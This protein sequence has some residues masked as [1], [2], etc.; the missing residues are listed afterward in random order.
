M[1]PDSPFAPSRGS[2]VRPVPLPT[3]EPGDSPTFSLS[4]NC[5][6]LPFIRG[7]LQ[8]L[9]LQ[10]TW[11]TNDPAAL[12]QVQQRVFNLIDL[13]GE[14]S[15]L[16]IPF[17]CS[18]DL[19]TNASPYGTFATGFCGHWTPLIGYDSDECN[20]GSNTYQGIGIDLTFSTPVVLSSVS[21]HYDLFMG[22]FAGCSGPEVIEHIVDVT[23]SSV[24]Q[25]KTN[26]VLTNGG[27]QTLVRSGLTA[28]TSH[29]NVELDADIHCGGG[30][31]S[32]NCQITGIDIT[33]SSVTP[34]C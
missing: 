8:Q 25:T 1:W 6:W 24:L 32:G 23:N 30:S 15:S 28:P 27:G 12:L 19:R 10:E 29:I 2:F 7:G 4:I 14:C 26:A 18:G 33:G 34:P 17:A 11:A 21:I 5:Q 13:F 31:T 3:T 20:S 16:T 22:G 9:L